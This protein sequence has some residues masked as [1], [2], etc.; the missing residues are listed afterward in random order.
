M[1]ALAAT[2]LLTA[3][4]APIATP[5]GWS[6]PLA[7]ADTVLVSDGDTL[8]ALQGEDDSFALRWRFPDRSRQEDKD[9]DL[10]AI[11]GT[12]VVAEGTAYFGAYDDNV[13][14]LDLVTGRPRWQRPFATKGPV[15]GGVALGE[16]VVYAASDDGNLYAIDLK[17]GSQKDRFAAGDSIWAPPLYAQGIVYVATRAGH[18]F[19]L[20]GETLD[21][22]WDK[23]FQADA[24]LV[25]TPVLAGDTVLIG[26]ID[27]QL[28]AVDAGSGQENWSFKA[29]NWFWTRPLVEG[30]VVYAGSLDGKVYALDL[31]SGQLVWEEPFPAQAPIRAAP[32]LIAGV[33]VVAD[34]DGN[35]YGLDPA[36]GSLKWDLPIPL[37]DDVLGHPIP[38][39]DHVLISTQGGLL[40]RI[41][42]AGAA[43]RI[44]VRGP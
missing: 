22:L 41:D 26:G 10:Q 40:F 8:F 36:S 30:A 25:S 5:Q 19:A 38:L 17:R 23:P 44:T 29:D 31:A 42:P 33:L 27:R 37:G 14:A 28:Y 32:V 16:D 7:T 21:P 39:A 18:L 4:C 35:L 9:I 13:Y 43:E 2:L 12:P 20:D 1:A 34:R 11:Y 24:G 3:A 15:I 6:G